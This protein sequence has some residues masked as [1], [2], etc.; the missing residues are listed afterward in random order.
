M[1]CSDKVEKVNK[2]KVCSFAYFDYGGRSFWTYLASFRSQQIGS[3]KLQFP[4]FSEDT[5]YSSKDY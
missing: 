3:T 1:V 2:T 4:D 5:S